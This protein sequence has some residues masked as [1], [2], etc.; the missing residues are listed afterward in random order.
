MYACA[1]GYDRN[2]SNPECSSQEYPESVRTLVLDGEEYVENESGDFKSWKC[3]DFSDEGKTLVEV[4]H[5]SIPDDYKETDEYRSMDASEKKNLSRMVKMFGF[6]LFDGTNSGEK[7][8]YT[9]EGLNHRWDWGPD[10]D[11]YALIIKPNGTGLF[12]DFSTAADGAKQ[13]ADD[14][15]RCRR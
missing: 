15:Y 8:I 1:A 7:A 2:A 4:G 9:H 5:V 11:T 12:Y 13:K 10:S 6:I 3:R 14:I